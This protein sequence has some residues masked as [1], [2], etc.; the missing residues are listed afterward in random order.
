M[1]ISKLK[2]GK[3]KNRRGQNIAVLLEEAENP[4]GLLL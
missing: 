4:K 1:K 2:K 3:I